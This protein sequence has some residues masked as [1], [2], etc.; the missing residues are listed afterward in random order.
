MTSLRCEQTRVLLP[1]WCKIG[2]FPKRS[3]VS[4]RCW[5]SLALSLLTWERNSKLKQRDFKH[6]TQFLFLLGLFGASVTS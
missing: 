3:V 2:V 5:L 1:V 4:E 6:L